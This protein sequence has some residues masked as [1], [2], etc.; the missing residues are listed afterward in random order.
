LDLQ[1]S[2]VTAVI[3]LLFSSADDSIPIDE[4]ISRT[5]LS[6][7]VVKQHLK[8]LVNGKYKLLVKVPQD[9]YST[10]HKIR[11]NAAFS[12]PQRRIRIPNVLKSKKAGEKEREAT[13]KAV[14]ED[15]KYSMDAAIV[16]LMKS[17]K[18]MNHQQL[19]A[20]VSAQLMRY[21]QPDPKEIKKRVEDLIAREYLKR[22][23][24]QSNLYHYLA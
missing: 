12:D 9:G 22:D 5:G 8:I 19:V 1:M 16:R 23:D 10:A 14:S 15:R 20:D 3:L 17:R 6:G 2:T 13:N 18:T 7:E 4:I 11:V 24:E 21:F